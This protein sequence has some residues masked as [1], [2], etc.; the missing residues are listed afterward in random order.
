MPRICVTR[1]VKNAKF[2]QATAP[3]IIPAD[4]PLEGF[5]S[6]VPLDQLQRLHL[7]REDEVQNAKLKKFVRTTDIPRAGILPAAALF[8][9]SLVFARITFN[10]PGGAVGVSAADM[11]PTT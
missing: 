1:A 10:T 7:L 5:T 4:E 9:G 2:L 11:A 8:A 6:L 3:Q